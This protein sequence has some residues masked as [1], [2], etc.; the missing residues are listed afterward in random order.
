M[1]STKFRPGKSGPANKSIP[2]KADLKR[3]E[4]K[5]VNP[6]KHIFNRTTKK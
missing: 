3:D 6:D 2:D 1:S 4:K 5:P